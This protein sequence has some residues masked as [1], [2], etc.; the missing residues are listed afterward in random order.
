MSYLKTAQEKKQLCFTYPPMYALRKPVSPESECAHRLYSIS[1][2]HGLSWYD[3]GAR[4]IYCSAKPVRTLEDMQG[5]HIRVQESEMMS[6]MM[7]ALGAI[8]VKLSF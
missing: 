3:A 4:N 2:P 6:E 5:M 8:P 1:P 7:T